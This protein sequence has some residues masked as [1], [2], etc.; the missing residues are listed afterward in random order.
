TGLDVRNAAAQEQF[1]INVNG[2]V[3]GGDAGPVAV[4]GYLGNGGVGLVGKNVTVVMGAG[5]SISGGIGSSGQANAIEFI[6]GSF[7][8]LVFTGSTSQLH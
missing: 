2:A 1:T 7:N 5:G 8:T 6:Y 3:A 4:N